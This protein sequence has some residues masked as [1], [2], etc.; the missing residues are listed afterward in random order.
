MGIKATN[1][2]LLEGNNPTDIWMK[3]RLL[4]K[5]HITHFIK[6]DL[7]TLTGGFTEILLAGI[8]LKCN[9]LTRFMGSNWASYC[10]LCTCFCYTLYH[11]VNNS[12]SQEVFTAKPAVPVHCCHCAFDASNSD[13]LIKLILAMQNALMLKK[14]WHRLLQGRPYLRFY[15]LLY[16]SLYPRICLTPSALLFFHFIPPLLSSNTLF[17]PPSPLAFCLLTCV[18]PYFR[19]P[20]TLPSVHEIS[21]A[22]VTG[23]KYHQGYNILKMT[24]ASR[25]HYQV[26]SFIVNVVWN[27]A[28]HKKKRKLVDFYQY[29]FTPFY[30]TV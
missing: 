25:L 21:V 2:T 4:P 17:P 6:M 15:N 22:I 8:D 16:T 7:I 18:F 9:N 29:G 27:I 23:L 13:R 10:C 19:P 3:V 14:G 24:L 28:K 26:E 20:P 12:S 11:T 1:C 5:L 30:F